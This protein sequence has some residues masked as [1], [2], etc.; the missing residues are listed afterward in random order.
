MRKFLLL[1][2]LLTTFVFP[3][4]AARDPSAVRGLRRAVVQMAIY[5]CVYVVAILYVLPR[6]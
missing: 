6:L 3:M 5:V 2:I 1:S 4:R